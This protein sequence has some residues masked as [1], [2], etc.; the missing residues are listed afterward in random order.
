MVI[1][2]NGCFCYNLFCITLCMV[3][4]R[5]ANRALSLAKTTAS[6]YYR[7]GNGIKLSSCICS[8]LWIPCTKIGLLEVN[9]FCL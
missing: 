7:R 2:I 9:W 6:I 1:R 4:I 3:I 8:W 5:H